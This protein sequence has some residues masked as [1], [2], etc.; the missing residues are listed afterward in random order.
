MGEPAA[1]IEIHPPASRAEVGPIGPV[2]AAA[3]L[4]DPVWI[5]IGP[6][7]RR[8]RALTNRLSFWGSVRASARHRA[9]IRI[10][11]GG[12]GGPAAPAGATISFEPGTWPPPDRA[13]AW[14]LPWALASGPLP[15]RRGM[16][17]DAIMRR[18]H[19]RHTHMYLWFIGVDPPLHGRGIG[20][21]LMVDV[22]RRS[23]ELGLP[24]YL[25]TGTEA[26][27]GFYES[28]GYEVL[29]E[30]AMP[31]DARMWRMER[32]AGGGG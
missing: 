27:V 3:F 22:H 10:A 28:F 8:H 16:R 23:E 32:P 20:R 19:V 17:A 29:G 11:Q 12:G 24:T 18:T 2:L 31:G 1:A 4:D 7:S 26:N 14:E 13:F 25:E 5:G 30:I 15:L 9:R 6:R 21:A